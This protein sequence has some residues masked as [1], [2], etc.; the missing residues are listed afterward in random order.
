MLVILPPIKRIKNTLFMILVQAMLWK[1]IFTAIF[2]SALQ[3]KEAS[4][5]AS[6]SS[7]SSNDI[8]VVFS[9]DRPKLHGILKQ[10]SRTLSE[11]SEEPLSASWGREAFSYSR[12]NR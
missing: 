10:R 12:E 2:L 9:E 7:E 6:C 8:E 5:R 4:S 11:S 3:D 1:K